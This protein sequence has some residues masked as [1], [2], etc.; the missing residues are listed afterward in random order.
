MR[1]PQRSAEEVLGL[2]RAV[3]QDDPEAAAT[4]DQLRRRLE[5]PLRVALVGS[6]KAGKSTLLNAL[7]GE[8]VAP[9]DAR[10]CTRI[11]TWYRYGAT[12]SVRLF[13]RDGTSRTMPPRRQDERLELDLAD[14]D[15][16]RI[17]RLEI[18]WP[19]D[20]LR[21]LTLVDTPG[22]VSVSEDVSSL[23]DAFLMPED[24]AASGADAVLYLLRSLHTSDVAFLR[25]L[26]E[27]TRHGVS[28]VGAVAVLSRV[29]ELGAGRL[30]AMISVN[31]AVEKLRNDP[32]LAGVCETVV[33]VAG[34]LGLGAATLRQ[35]DFVALA[36][37]EGV[38]RDRMRR[39]MA[40]PEFFIAAEDAELPTQQAR[41]G[42][43]DRLG[44]YGIRLA[45]AVLRGGVRDAPDLAAE[46]GRR[47]GFDELRRVLDVNFVQR[48]VE[49]KA[50]S[51]VLATLRL[52]RAQPAPGSD[53]VVARAEEHLADAHAFREM[54]LIGRVVAERVALDRAQLTEL[55][56]VIGGRGTAPHDRLGDE[57]G[58][59]DP[60]QL[61]EL[62]V[63]HV[64]RW[65]ALAANPLLD[66][67]T[68]EACRVAVRSCEGV[69]AELAELVPA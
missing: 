19:S 21:G 45:M 59:L 60:R 56:R 50:H 42:L 63:E 47:S 55:E 40:S 30:G 37:L 49:L 22:T 35:S 11:V 1:S 31:Q 23:T 18:T 12:P 26:H 13:H 8:R 68:V 51:V 20:L 16:E 24:G 58:A 65:R 39:L 4:I 62:A 36:Q 29:D 57:S 27:R 41:A 9:T 7:L 15:V 3:Y 43:V 69:V 38:S 2:A 44:L 6:V 64:R 46:L 48:R 34:L 10:E 66:R 25:A 61:Q 67:S 28:A 5:E 53:E 54:Q 32:A 33:P 17:D 52:A 14:A